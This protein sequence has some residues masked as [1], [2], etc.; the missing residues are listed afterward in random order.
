MS[1]PGEFPCGD[2]DTDGSLALGVLLDQ[3]ISC[4]L[5]SGCDEGAAVEALVLSLAVE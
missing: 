3:Q 1:R 5:S 4:R 2:L